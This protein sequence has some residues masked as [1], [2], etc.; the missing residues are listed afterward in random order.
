MEKECLERRGKVVIALRYK[1]YITGMQTDQCSVEINIL[2]KLDRV[3][4]GVKKTGFT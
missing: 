4:D 2:L 1:S 3:E